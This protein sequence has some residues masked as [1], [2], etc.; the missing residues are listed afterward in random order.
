[1]DMNALFCKLR[2]LSV[3]LKILAVL[4]VPLVFAFLCAVAVLSVLLF[5]LLWGIVLAC[6]AAALFL[7]AGAIAGI[8]G[9]F[10]ALLSQTPT[11]AALLAGSGIFCAGVFILWYRVCT[12]ATVLA[13]LIC[14]KAEAFRDRFY[15]RKAGSDEK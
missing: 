3:P 11:Q 8:G 6:Y 12:Q 2:T 5:L 7:A 14:R 13:K 10:F 1:M 9:G 15:V 4:A